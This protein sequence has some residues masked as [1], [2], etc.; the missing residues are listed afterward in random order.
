MSLRTRLGAAWRGL[1]AKDS[2]GSGNPHY[3]ALAAFVDVYGSRH[4]KSGQSVTTD[5][6]LRNATTFACQRVIG[7]GIGQSPCDIFRE[8]PDGKGKDIAK[9][10]A[11]YPIFTLAPNTVQ[12]PFEF[13]ETLVFHASLAGNFIA[14]KNYAGRTLRELIPIEPGTWG[15]KQNDDLSLTYK[16]RNKAGQE[17]EFA[18]N[19]IWHVRGPSWNGVAGMEMIKQ[20]REAIGL[21]MAIE[22][23][24]SSLYKNGLRSSG[25]YSVEG[26]LN[27][28]QYKDL[29]QFI[30]DYQQDDSGGPLILDRAAKYLQQTMSAVDAQTLESRK[31]Q[32]EEICRLFRVM[33]IMIGHA[34][35]QSPTFASAEQFFIA[36]VVHTLLPWCRRI[37]MSIGK[38]LISRDDWDNGVRAKFNLTALMRGS[39][40]DR[41]KAFGAMLGAGGSPPYAEINEV[42]DLDDMN[43]VDWGNGKP[44]PPAP[45]TAP[46]PADAPKV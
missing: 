23:D 42:R 43:P 37:E 40:A 39:F 24:Q 29:R 41:Q 27:E 30:K 28:N 33:P 3:D 2:G 16:I 10:H 38:N 45:P 15:V 44:E 21:S 35:D 34:G 19:L 13:F 36:H 14:F 9:D 12:T 20:A 31:L 17:R 11:L 26:V 1:S 25:V 32:I 8:R 18:Q 22:A 4:A 46:K 5:S 6:A 7:E